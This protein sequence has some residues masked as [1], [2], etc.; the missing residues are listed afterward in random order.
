[1]G[2]CSLHP[3]MVQ[4]LN[5]SQLTWPQ[6]PLPSEPSCQHYDFLSTFQSQLFSSL[7]V[8]INLNFFH[9][10][11]PCVLSTL[12]VYARTHALVSVEVKGQ[13][14]GVGAFLQEAVRVSGKCF[15][16]LSHLTVI[17]PVVFVYTGS[18]LVQAGLE[19]AV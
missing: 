19:L 7:G 4:G 9:P 18:H 5:S 15:C 14:A 11:H 10:I 17:I 2:A 13:L 6:V 8:V 16:P 12:Y 1:M 3:P